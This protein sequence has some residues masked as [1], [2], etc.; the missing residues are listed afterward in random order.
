MD[1]FWKGLQDSIGMAGSESEWR[2]IDIRMD[3]DVAG[4]M[5]GHKSKGRI[6][7]FLVGQKQRHAQE[8]QA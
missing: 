5:E 2:L 7:Q 1:I 8:E 6:D 3:R 4:R